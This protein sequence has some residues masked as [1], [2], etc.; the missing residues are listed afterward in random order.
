MIF[1]YK[2][3]KFNIE[4]YL[5]SLPENN[6]QI[7]ISHKKLTYILDNISRFKNLQ[8]SD[9]SNNYLISL[10]NLSKLI[11]LRELDCSDNELTLLPYLS[12]LTHL[13]ELICYNNKLPKIININT[14]YL[15]EQQRIFITQF[16]KWFINNTNEI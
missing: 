1:A 14:S 7:D 9:C 2:M 11:R 3:T 15:T 12:K 10:P 13:N 5:N 16:V 8:K 4:E 6:T